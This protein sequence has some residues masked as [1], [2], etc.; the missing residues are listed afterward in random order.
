MARHGSRRR[1]PPTGRPE[2]AALVFAGLV[3]G[4]PRRSHVR[5]RRL[6]RRR[7]ASGRRRSGSPARRRARGVR[8]RMAA[9]CLESAGPGPRC[10]G[11]WCF[12][13]HGRARPS[14]G[15][16][17]PIAAGT[18]STRAWRTPRSSG[19]GSCSRPSAARVPRAS[20]PR[21]SRSSSAR[22]SC[23]RFWRRPCP[24]WIP[25][26]IGSPACGSRSGYWNALALLADIALV[27]G[28][29]L[30]TAPAHRRSRAR[31]GRSTRLRRDA[32]AHAHALARGC[33]RRESVCSRSG[34]CCRA[35]ECRAA[36]CCSRPRYRR[37]RSGPGRSRGRR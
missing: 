9:E 33:R 22:R 3:G 24:R 28:L 16:S 32:R 21:C 12:S 11:R 36:S 26:A 1:S 6:G 25:T 20:L 34:S 4:S 19:S 13:S 30:G 8:L 18:P 29:W 35:S 31:R 5:R 27:L 23:G 7:D 17:S 15:R 2:P 14:R 37:S 10:S